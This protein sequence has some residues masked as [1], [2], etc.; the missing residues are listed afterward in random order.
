MS[1]QHVPTFTKFSESTKQDWDNITELYKR[2]QG[3]VANQ[4]LQQLQKLDGELDGYPVTRLEHSLQTAT[5]A[6][7]DGQS[8]E[9]VMCALL[10]DIGDNH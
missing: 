5:R 7:R 3:D 10:H 8:M 2:T 9:Y 1:S 4:V 6:E